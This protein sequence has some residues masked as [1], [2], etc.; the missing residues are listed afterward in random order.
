MTRPTRPT[1]CRVPADARDAG[2]SSVA[3]L[4][5]FVMLSALVVVTATS[6]A[7]AT[8]PAGR[9]TDWVRAGAAAE[10]GI[11]D[12]LGRLRDDP[13]A[14]STID[15]DDPALVGQDAAVVDHSCPWGVDEVGWAAVE[16]DADPDASPAYH[17]EVTEAPVEAEPGWA[18]AVTVTVTGRSGAVRRTLEVRFA[19]ASTADFALHQDYG[20]VEATAWSESVG[21]AAAAGLAAGCGSAG[22]SATARDVARDPACANAAVLG[23]GTAVTGDVFSNDR[24][25]VDAAAQVDGQVATAHPDCAPADDDPAGWAACV[26]LVGGST[27]EDLLDGH[28][29]TSA[30]PLTLPASTAGY[31]DLPGC[32]YYGETRVVGHGATMTVRAPSTLDAGNALGLPTAVAAPGEPAPD[33]GDPHLLALGTAQTIPVPDAVGVYVHTLAVSSEPVASGALGA[34]SAVGAFP[35]GSLTSVP[36]AA[37]AV[38]EYELE[39][40]RTHRWTGL[41]TLY[42]EGWFSP[43]S[44]A[45]EGDAGVTFV[46][47]ESVVVTGDVLSTGSDAGDHCADATRTCLIGIVAGRSVE[48]L[49]PVVADVTAVTVGTGADERVEW[50]LDVPLGVDGAGAARAA[51]GVAGAAGWPDGGWPRRYVDRARGTVHP[52]SGVQIQAAV[53]ALGGTLLVQNHWATEGVVAGVPTLDVVVTGS[54]AVRFAGLQ[55]RS[56][57]WAPDVTYDPALRTAAPP[58]LLPFEES[59][60]WEARHVTE[61]RAG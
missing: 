12:Y 10:S 49:N 54:L 31:A 7:Q 32:H 5:A 52:A 36:P 35:L 27:V 23:A 20:V 43:G 39:Q 22:A 8:R 45:S 37:G 59:T 61:L 26:D 58:Y 50:D 13:A 46:A 47:D 56:S 60:P 9:Q 30:T 14:W 24:L 41:G 57:G 53:Q 51:T 29:P 33:C 21:A 25:A 34:S 55:D 16:P 44:A 18:S 38:A 2:M 11:A 6:A 3:V 19:R 42:L 15:C 28:A 17:Y 1:G 40:T 48:V 4:L